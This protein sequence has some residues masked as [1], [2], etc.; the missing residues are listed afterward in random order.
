MEYERNFFFFNFRASFF[1]KAIS[2]DTNF[3][4]I[5][6]EGQYHREHRVATAAF[7]R[8]FSDEGKIGPGW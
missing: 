8:T 7:W 5:H 1:N 2:N 4:Q 6:L 3:S